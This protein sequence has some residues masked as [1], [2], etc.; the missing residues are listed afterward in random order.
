MKGVASGQIVPTRTRRERSLKTSH[1]L[2]GGS[3]A[4]PAT[5]SVNRSRSGL[6]L[7]AVSTSI[8]LQG[9]QNGE[10]DDCLLHELFQSNRDLPTK[11]AYAS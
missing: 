9:L 11:T 3:K 8:G 10:K 6:Y 5:L 4:F 7:P 1:R 2:F